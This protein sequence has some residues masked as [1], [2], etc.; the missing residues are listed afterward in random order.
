MLSGIN[1]QAKST[2]S[3]A[4]KMQNW[5]QKLIW[6][7]A[8]LIG[9]LV[10]P[11]MIPMSTYTRQAESL[12]EKSLGVP[13]HIGA[14][15]LAILPTPRLNASDLVVGANEEFRVAHLSVLPA[16]TSL[17]SE[18]KVISS[19]KIDKPI[20]KKAALDIVA[21]LS[22]Q[23]K[24]T[25]SKTTVSVQKIRINQTTLIWPGM[26]L[27]EINAEI[28]LNEENLPKTAKLESVDGKLKLDLTPEENRQIITFSARAWTLPAGP[29]LL[30][31]KLDMNMVLTS[32]KLDILNIDA[33]LY[34]GNLSSHA[35]LTW[36]KAYK[37]NGKM[38]L[39]NLAVHEPVRLISKSSRVSGQLSCSGPFSA[40]AK[41]AGQLMDNLQANIQFNVKNGVLYGFD[42]AKASL[43]L[44]GQGK[45]GETKFDAFTG[46]LDIS[47]KTY[48]FRNLNIESG[49]MAANGEVKINPDKSLNGKVEVEVK[50]SA[51]IAAI[52][53]EISGTLENPKVFPTKAAIAGAVA[54]TAVLGPAGTGLGLKA[55]N[56]V[57]KL[58]GLFGN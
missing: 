34:G 16:I 1:D 32:N 5:K 35:I 30:L 10:I 13:V 48:R 43:M 7:S 21:A 14:L 28:D 33:A 41:E 56:A 17:F 25:T 31:D 54:G 8:I 39:D 29:P 15:H 18:K 53:L 47:A 9:L 49:L 26:H 44:I 24:D 57:D 51:S 52:P 3:E 22:G 45:G 23:P 2:P 11:L 58:K 55:G 36:G 6:T 46:L 19:I 4:G 12:A 40:T 42:L 27:P 20:I 37:L 38:K 50:K